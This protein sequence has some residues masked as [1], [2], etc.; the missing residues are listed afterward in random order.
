MVSENVSACFVVLIDRMGTGLMHGA[1][2]E[3]ED[4][5]TQLAECIQAGKCNGISPVGDVKNAQPYTTSN[6][7]SD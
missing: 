4:V 3:G 6:S 1:Y 7:T 5:A 2:F